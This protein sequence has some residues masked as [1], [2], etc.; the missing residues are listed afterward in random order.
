M[1]LQ[2]S[3]CRLSIGCLSHFSKS[4]VT[5]GPHTSLPYSI[6]GSITDLNIFIQTL[7]GISI[8]EDFLMDQKA[9]LPLS[10]RSLMARLKFPVAV[11]FNPRYV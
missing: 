5:R 3:V 9:L 11:M 8:H 1:F 2:I 10:R 7:T 4:W 6:I